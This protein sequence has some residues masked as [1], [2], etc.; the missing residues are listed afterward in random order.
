MNESLYEAR[1]LSLHATEAGW[2]YC[3]RRGAQSAVMIFAMTE[4]KKVILVEEYRPPVD[5]YTICFPAGLHGDTDEAES[6]QATAGREFFEEAGYEADELTY[7]FQGPSSPG[8]TS[9][10]VAFFLATQ[11][12]RRGEGGGVEN[13]RIVVHE[14]ALDSIIQWLQQQQNAGK[15]IDPRVYTGLYFLHQHA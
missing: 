13:E 10:M 7:L 3:A 5:A 14:I 8:L 2:E 1:F 12:R 6:L 4:E 15:L 11:I 9:E